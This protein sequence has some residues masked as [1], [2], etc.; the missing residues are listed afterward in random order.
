MSQFTLASATQTLTYTQLEW[1]GRGLVRSYM[2]STLVKPLAYSQ[3]GAARITGPSH[4]PRL[5]W[6]VDLVLTQLRYD[7][8]KAFLIAHQ[9]TLIAGSGFV[10]LSDYQP[11]V[12]SLPQSYPGTLITSGG[13]QVS[14]YPVIPVVLVVEEPLGQPVGAGPRYAVRLIA[15]QVAT[16][17]GEFRL[18]PSIAVNLPRLRCEFPCTGPSSLVTD[19][20][21]VAYGQRICTCATNVTVFGQLGGAAV[22][23]YDLEIEVR[24]LVELYNFTGG[25]NDGYYWQVGGSPTNPFVNWSKLEISNPSQYFY[26]NR[27]PGGG[28][29]LG[30]LNYRKV[31][32]VAGNALITMLMDS[33]DRPVGYELSNDQA[34]IAV[35]VPG[36]NPYPRAFPGQFLEVSI[37][38]AT[39]I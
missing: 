32:R 23:L 28:L 39:K 21:S 4:M 9:N 38:G 19:V 8:L 3:I 27:S 14:Y 7:E 31:I 18:P 11:L 26:L 36:I 35:A 25:T 30:Q 20:G 17:Y 10:T 33:G 22:D 12:E 13:G 16:D 5:Q 2:P 15:R 29:Y 34:G 6:A 1:S 37:V 24:G